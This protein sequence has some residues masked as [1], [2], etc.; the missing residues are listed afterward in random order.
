MLRG[1]C[2]GWKGPTDPNASAG[3][4]IGTQSGLVFWLY[5]E[6][7]QL[8][9]YLCYVTNINQKIPELLWSCFVHV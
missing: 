5:I 1:L 9:D 6:C 8:H 2:L 4:R 7:P 3:V